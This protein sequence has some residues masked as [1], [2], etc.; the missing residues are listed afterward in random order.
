MRSTS[1][2]ALAVLCLVGLPSLAGPAARGLQSVD[3]SGAW[4]LTVTTDLTVTLLQEG[5]RLTGHYSS[6]T[7]GEADVAGAV[8]EREVTFSFAVE[9]QGFPIDV[10]YTGTLDGADMMEGTITLAGLGQ[11]TFT[12]RREPE[13]Q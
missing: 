4:V 3:V 1:I 10:S 8:S 2:R 5:D 12:G 6:E 9:L 7:L 13:A 11:G